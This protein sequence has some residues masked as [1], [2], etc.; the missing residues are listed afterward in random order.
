M[1]FRMVPKQK[2]PASFLSYRFRV[3]L[4]RM[5]PKHTFKNMSIVFCFR[6]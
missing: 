5:V 1:L 4:F 3:M 2:H 6:V